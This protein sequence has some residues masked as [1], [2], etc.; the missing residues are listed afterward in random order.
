MAKM[1][2]LGSVPGSNGSDTVKI[3]ADPA[4]CWHG[5]LLTVAQHEVHQFCARVQKK[6]ASDNQHE[7]HSACSFQ[8]KPCIV[9]LLE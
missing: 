3:A 6:Q 4:M 7:C 9:N 8:G 5:L 2:S 1:A